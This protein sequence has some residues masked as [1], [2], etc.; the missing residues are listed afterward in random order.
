MFRSIRTFIAILTFLAVTTSQGPNRAGAADGPTA[1]AYLGGQLLVAAP[2]MT[3]PNFSETV[4]V[5]VDHNAGGAMGLV[6]NRSM[7]S[8]QLKALLGGFGIESETAS[9]TV[10][11]HS[12]GP[13]EAGRGFV[14][15]STDYTGPSTRV[16]NDGVAVSTGRDILEAIGTG[17]GPRVARFILGY[18]GW[19][20][21]QLESEMAR[22][23]WLTAPAE[24]SLVFEEDLDAV[25]EKAIESGG[26]PL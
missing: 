24:P 13:V 16:V 26:V 22:D 12:G 3:D 20:P 23:D 11:L 5:M 8:G 19:G 25:W 15:H 9:G 18:A 2:K 1:S 14:L 10:R 6:V 7:G 17:K 4:I 21:G